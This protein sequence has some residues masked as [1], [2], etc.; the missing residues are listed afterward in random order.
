MLITPLILCGGSGT[1]L[2]PASRTS[3]PKQFLPLFGPRSS[4]QE[5]LLRVGDADLFDRAVVISHREHRSLVEHQLD[6]SKNLP[7]SVVI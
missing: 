5:T 7:E 2:W 4:F 1:R 3:R 6:T